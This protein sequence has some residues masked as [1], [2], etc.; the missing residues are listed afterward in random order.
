MSWLIELVR[1]EAK[2]RTQV[3]LTSEPS[4]GVRLIDNVQHFQEVL[5]ATREEL[6]FLS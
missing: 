1:G 5:R 2:I 4:L 6:D 3:S